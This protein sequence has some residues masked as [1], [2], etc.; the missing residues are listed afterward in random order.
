MITGLVIAGS[1]ESRSIEWVPDPSRA[2]LI[3]SNPKCAFAASIAARSDPGPLSLAFTTA[4]AGEL[5]V[6]LGGVVM[7]LAASTVLTACDKTTGD[8]AAAAL[9]VTASNRSGSTT[10]RVA[11]NLWP[12]PSEN[13]AFVISGFVMSGLL[14]SVGAVNAGFGMFATSTLCV[15]NPNSQLSAIGVV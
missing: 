10:R 2:K 5:G 14:T 11:R 7:P 8:T 4:S 15:C 1:G 12:G 9:K 6:A 13:V 3:V